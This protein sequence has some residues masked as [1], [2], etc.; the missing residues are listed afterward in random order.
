VL[1]NIPSTISP[2]L[3]YLIAQMG[4]GDELVLADA[5]FPCVEVGRRVV[6]ADGHFVADL[7]KSILKLFPLDTFVLAP[8]AVMQRV[9]CPD[10]PADVWAEYQIV[11]NDAE[12]RPIEIERVERFDFYDRARKA[13][14]IVATGETALYGNLIIKKGVIGPEEE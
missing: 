11:L 10:L 2:E 1:K 3:L 8:A 9:D 12:F 4:H 5:N 14:G 7:L 13:F 6:R